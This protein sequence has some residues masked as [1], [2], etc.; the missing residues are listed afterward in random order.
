MIQKSSGCS[1]GLE[2]GNKNDMMKFCRYIDW[3]RNIHTGFITPTI[4][5]LMH[6]SAAEQ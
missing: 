3:G 6:D 5:F 2:L 4:W 1:G